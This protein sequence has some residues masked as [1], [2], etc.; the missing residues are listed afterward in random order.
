MIISPTVI[1]M[2]NIANAKAY[3][4]S[5]GILIGIS[6]LHLNF[7]SSKGQRKRRT[8]F[9]CEYLAIDN[10]LVNI[11]I[12]NKGKVTYGIPTGSLTYDLTPL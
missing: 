8:H 9:N 11:A 7:A 6:Y 2:T 1:D 3:K 5:C 12:V 4:V 10:R